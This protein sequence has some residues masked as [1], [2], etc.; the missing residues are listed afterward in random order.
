MEHIKFLNEEIE[1]VNNLNDTYEVDY[2]NSKNYM[3]LTFLGT[4][5]P[6]ITLVLNVNMLNVLMMG[7]SMVASFVMFVNFKRRQS[8]YL[9]NRMFFSALSELKEIEMNKMFK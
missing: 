9:G 4:I 1:R 2:T 7:L 8:D 3:V 5:L 6:V